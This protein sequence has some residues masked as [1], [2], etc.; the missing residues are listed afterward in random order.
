MAG[1]EEK[2]RAIDT[3]KGEFCDLQGV[4]SK[5]SADVERLADEN[6]QLRVECK[7][8]NNSLINLEEEK[9]HISAECS[10][11][12]EGRLPSDRIISNYTYTY[13][14]T[15]IY[16]LTNIYYN[17]KYFIHTYIHTYVH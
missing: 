5:L 11:L 9:L 14:H 2:D 12:H 8:A 7:H 4:Y 15:Y 1:G 13:T 6:K 17:N 10:Q 16:I 3:L